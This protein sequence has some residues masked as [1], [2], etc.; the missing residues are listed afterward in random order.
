MNKKDAI[1][2]RKNYVWISSSPFN[3]AGVGGGGGQ[4]AQGAEGAG[5]GRKLLFHK[6]KQT[7]IWGLK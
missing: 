1:K 4:G 7:D 6:T 5:D 3:Q 2:I